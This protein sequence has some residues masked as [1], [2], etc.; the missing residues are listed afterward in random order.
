[1]DESVRRR[2]GCRVLDGRFWGS[3]ALF[4]K[5]KA[6]YGRLVPKTYHT[7]PSLTTA[8]V[9]LQLPPVTHPRFTPCSLWR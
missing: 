9:T 7:C 2:I 5:I 6:A 8:A 3:A 1:M 4:G